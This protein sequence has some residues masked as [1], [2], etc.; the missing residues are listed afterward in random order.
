MRHTKP[1]KIISKI[2]YG[3]L[4]NYALKKRK[5]KRTRSEEE[6]RER[7]TITNMR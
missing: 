6:E 1:K 2:F 4:E 3:L 7:L 5:K